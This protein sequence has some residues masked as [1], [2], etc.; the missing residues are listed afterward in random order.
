MA[1]RLTINVWAAGLTAA[2]LSAVG[3]GP[4]F[5]DE[6]HVYEGE[7][8]QAAIDGASE[9]D[10][11][12][13]HP[14]TYI[15]NID[16][17][18][19]AIG[20]R[21]SDG[22]DVTTIQ[23]QH[24]GPIVHCSTGEGPDTVLEG[25]TITGG[26]AQGGA[27]LKNWYCNPTVRDCIFVGNEASIYGG[28]MFNYFSSPTVIDCTFEN[29][30]A[31][32]RGG[33]IYNSH[34]APYLRGCTFR[35]NLASNGS[36]AAF[37]SENGAPVIIDC[38]FIENT[39]LVAGGGVAF[40]DDSVVMLNCQ[41]IGNHAKKSSGLAQS[42][43]DSLIVGCLFLGNTADE[44][45][46]GLATH[47]TKATII[48]CTLAMNEAPDIAGLLIVGAQSEVTM[49][50]CVLWGNTDDGGSNQHA[51]ISFTYSASPEDLHMDYSCVQGWT[52]EYGGTGNFGEDPLF[53]DP[54][55]DD[56]RLLPGSPCIDAGFNN[57][58][59]SDS[60]DLDDD[61]FT[62]ERFPIDL[63]GNSRFADD[64]A[65]NDTGCGLPVVVDMG[66]FEYAGVPADVV[67]CDIDG[68]GGVMIDDVFEVLA[69]WGVCDGCCLSDLNLDGLVGID[70]IF[71]V[72]ANWG[73]CS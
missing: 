18:G 7:S 39:A 6:I 50:N 54:D 53:V 38:A 35:D 4:V 31:L 72:L 12:I 14:G 45:G 23:A 67:Y 59:A 27:G 21:S 5:A 25:L 34:S 33:A 71:E 63:D 2:C 62:C 52:G 70:D 29:N 16:L 19:K 42:F 9:G 68:D 58:L 47:E 65:T 56:V 32:D 61:G 1:T 24:D 55:N 57:I 28:A 11:I 8:I 73:P 46:A 37:W 51:Q 22:P 66:A 49:A 15:E 20:V 13:V 60:Y 69:D 17:L 36:G 3:N 41:M 44:F 43:C 64:P 10:E 26:W 40:D 30:S 48:N